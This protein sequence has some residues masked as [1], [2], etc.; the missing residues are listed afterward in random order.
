MTAHTVGQSV[1]AEQPG[2]IVFGHHVNLGL[3]EPGP[4]QALHDCSQF[5]DVDITHLT[6]IG[7]QHDV[8]RTHYYGDF[9]ATNSSNEP[10]PLKPARYRRA[11]R[12]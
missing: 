7:R 11:N 1:E 3:T 9:R 8:F 6:E 4:R 12:R 10:S 5:V 2:G